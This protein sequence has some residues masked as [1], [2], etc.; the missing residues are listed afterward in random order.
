MLIQ[1]ESMK[2]LPVASNAFN[3]VVV[4]FSFCP[5]GEFYK[6]NFAQK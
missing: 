6:D 3:E 5:S 1:G 2:E 4:C